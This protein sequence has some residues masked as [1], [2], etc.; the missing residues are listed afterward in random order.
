MPKYEVKTSKGTFVVEADR[1]PTEAD[2]LAALG[3]KPSGPRLSPA[4]EPVEAKNMAEADAFWKA[5]PGGRAAMLMKA[6]GTSRAIDPLVEGGGAAA[7]AR[8][9]G[10]VAG[11]PGAAIGGSLGALGAYA[12]NRFRTSTPATA[13]GVAGAAIMGAVPGAS[14]GAAGPKQVLMEGAK[15]GAANLAAK[16]A[17][18]GL[19]EGRLPSVGEAGMSVAGG[20]GGAAASKVLDMSKAGVDKDIA[21]AVRDRTLAEAQAAG[22]VIPPSRVN[23]N[24]VNKILESLAG[25][26]ATAQEAV[27]RNQEVTNALARKAVGA[28]PN[29]PLTEG[30]LRK[31]REDAAK[32]YEEIRT[33]AKQAESDLEALKKSRLTASSQHELEIQASDP[34]FVKEQA[35]LATKAAAKVDELKDAKFTANAYFTQW[36]K[37]GDPEVYKK[38]VAAKKTADGLEDAIIDAAEEIGKPELAQQLRDAR[39]RI[40]KV[41]QVEK[42]LNLGDGNISAPILG[43]SLDSGKPLTQELA[44]IGKFQQ[45]FPQSARELA[46]TP[47]SGVNQLMPVAMGGL[48][49]LQNG[50]GLIAASMLGSQG[51]VRDMILSKP[52]QAAMTAP[53]PSFLANA[54]RLTAEAESRQQPNSFLQFLRQEFPKQAPQNNQFLNR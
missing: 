9:G 54:A 25:K 19:D 12:A 36:K 44:T 38:A 16:A 7:G 30:L 18:T 42:A 50:R 49:A 4:G 23:P 31:I 6:L 41:H 37:S 20:F 17:E 1:E 53:V 29:A 43:R 45:A 21:N 34:A 3:E 39:V 33:F 5:G 28:P 35:S 10:R 27:V 40:A 46:S 15:Q 47:T 24:P 11:F 13:G 51:L 22:Y 52:Y 8:I 14:L 48:A 2:V 26:A 32:P